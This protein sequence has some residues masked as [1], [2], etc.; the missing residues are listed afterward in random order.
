MSWLVWPG[1]GML[2]AGSLLPL[3]M[4]WRPVVRALRDLVSLPEARRQRDHR[5][6]PD[7]VRPAPR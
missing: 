2:L 4:D 6:A 5:R 3:L 7:G 1:L